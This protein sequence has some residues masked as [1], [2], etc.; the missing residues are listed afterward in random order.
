[1][2]SALSPTAL[3]PEPTGNASYVQPHWYA[4]YTFPRH[5][6]CV[7]QQLQQ[8][9][10]DHFLPLHQ[11]VH[12]WKDRR[13][14]VQLA[15]FPG[16]VFVRMTLKDQLGILQM[17]SVARLVSFQGR[18][19]ALPDAEIEA[20]RNG[21]AENLHAEPHPYLKLGRRVQVTGGPLAGVAG[22]L[23]HKKQSF[24]VVLSIEMIQRSVAV[25]IDI[26]DI[27]PAS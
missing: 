13:K 22:I 8:R 15:L 14:I 23:V 7:A 10:F 4:A 21:L 17:A 18:P 25:E 16:Y 5:E 11:E 9:G 19:A 12:R 26:R 20:L 27:A 24:R 2:I 1:M 3:C 6:K